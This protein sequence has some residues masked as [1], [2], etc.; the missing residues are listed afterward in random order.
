[1][2]SFKQDG[3]RFVVS[4]DNHQKIAEAIAAFCQEQG[5]YA[6]EIIG[7]GAVDNATLRF[8]N[9][10]TKAYVDKTFE[11]QMEITSLVGNISE[12]D[13]K[14]YLHL[15]ANFGRSD[16][17]VV[18]GHLLEARISGACEIFIKRYNCKVGRHKD[19]ETGLNMYTL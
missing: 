16:Y 14:V 11:E 3:D 4:I 19:E 18:G 7:L 8:L 1:M 10:D 2:Y 17:S 15:H 5:I 9:P 13:G 12:K 6:G